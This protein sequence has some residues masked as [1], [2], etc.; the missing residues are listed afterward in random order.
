VGREDGRELSRI[1]VLLSFFD[2][3]LAL[4]DRYRILFVLSD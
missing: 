4:L 2:E 3:L 1:N